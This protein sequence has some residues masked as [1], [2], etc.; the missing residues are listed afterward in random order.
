MCGEMA[1]RWSTWAGER[2]AALGGAALRCSVA[3]AISSHGLSAAVRHVRS[4]RLSSSLLQCLLPQ[5]RLPDLLLPSLLLC[6]RYDPLKVRGGAA[7]GRGVCSGQPAAF[8]RQR[9]SRARS[10]QAAL[11]PLMSSMNG[12]SGAAA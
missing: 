2:R 3:A 11:Q 6:C 12:T 9:C 10:W 8:L 4:W 7:A 1:P 5:L